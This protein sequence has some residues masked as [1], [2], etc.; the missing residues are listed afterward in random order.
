M[1]VDYKQIDSTLLQTYVSF[2]AWVTA[3]GST[4]VSILISVDIDLDGLT[5]ILPTTIDIFAFT[6]NS[7]F[8]NGAL[9]ISKMSARPLHR[10]FAADATITFTTRMTVF[11]EWWGAITGLD[12]TTAIQNAIDSIA[13]HNGII[14]LFLS[15]YTIVGDLDSYTNIHF[16][17]FTQSILFTKCIPESF[18]N[19]LN[20]TGFISNGNIMLTPE[21]GIAVRMINA[22]GVTLVKGN[23]LSNSLSIENGVILAA[24]DSSLFAGV[25]YDATVDPGNPVWCVNKG[26]AY[27]LTDANGAAFGDYVRIPTSYDMNGV[28]G[29]GHCESPNAGIDLMRKTGIS[30]N[31][32]TGSGLVLCQL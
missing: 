27:I 3:Q 6:N 10:I 31:E 26:K 8:K 7:Q 13:T 17:D 30:L 20:L 9:S 15:N 18:N 29:Q 1:A 5:V 23:Q 19:G 24:I 25:V 4:P 22:T 32:R 2:S 11:P 12:A 21:G 16:I 28:D 14:I